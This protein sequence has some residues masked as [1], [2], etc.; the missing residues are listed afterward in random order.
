MFSFDVFL[1]CSPLLWTEPMPSAVRCVQVSLS[2]VIVTGRQLTDADT[3]RLRRLACDNNGMVVRW[4]SQRLR[5]MLDGH[6][7]SPGDDRVRWTLSY[8]SAATTTTT[9][10]S[11]RQTQPVITA[12]LPVYSRHSHRSLSR[13]AFH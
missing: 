12:S 11:S 1:H 3:P 7:A 5:V 8:V 13:A 4:P 2:A 6:R 9:T 10:T